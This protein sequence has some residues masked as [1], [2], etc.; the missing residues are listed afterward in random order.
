MGFFPGKLRLRLQLGAKLGA[1]TRP[2]A[3]VNHSCCKDLQGRYM[4][5]SVSKELEECP[6]LGLRIFRAG[7]CGLS[8]CEQPLR[9]RI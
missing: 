5:A 2:P 7:L 1:R 4:R 6:A 8:Q 3:L 9:A